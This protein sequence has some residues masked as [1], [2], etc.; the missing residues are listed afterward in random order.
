VYV[1]V[2]EVNRCTVGAVAVTGLVTV[3]FG[4]V[5]PE[6]AAPPEAVTEV[7]LPHA[8]PELVSIPPVPD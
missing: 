5:P 2:P 3:I 1:P 8:A 4:V 7:T 6:E